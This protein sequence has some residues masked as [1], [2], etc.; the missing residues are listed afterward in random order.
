V[1]KTLIIFTIYIVTI[2]LLIVI[3][4]LRNS[5][6]NKKLT[7]AISELEKEKNLI[8]NAPI[9]N[10]LSKVEALVKDDKLKY[11]YDKTKVHENKTIKTGHEAR[12]SGR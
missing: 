9:L 3:F 7:Q 5:K 4:V 2:I 11:K 6:Q 8:I 12:S 10:E 1:N